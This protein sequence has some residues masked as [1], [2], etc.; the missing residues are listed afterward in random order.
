[1]LWLQRPP[2][3]R[4]ALAGTLAALALWFELRPL[5][6]VDHPFALVDIPPGTTIDGSNTE[7]RRVPGGLLDPAEG[8]IA[9]R[10]IRAGDPILSGDTTAGSKQIPIGW[11]VV[12]APVPPDSAP[13]Q[14]VK[15]ILLDSGET[16]D[17]VVTAVSDNDPFAIESGAIAVE[18]EHAADVAVASAAHRVAVLVSTG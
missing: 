14:K 13:G 11:W 17:G 9:A 16:I 3:A 18:S 15:V 2:W 1:M 10:L 12:S 6:T 4:W 5:P 7:L 8:D